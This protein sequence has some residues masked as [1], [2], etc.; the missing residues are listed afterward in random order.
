MSYITGKFF[1][2][3]GGASG[4]GLATCRMLAQRKAKAICIADYKDSQFGLVKTEL[5]GINAGA[6][7]IDLLKVDVSSSS[8]VAAWAEGVFS[9]YETLDGCVNAAGV[10][11]AVGARKDVVNILGESDQTWRRT[12]G[13][14]LDGVF[15]CNREQVRVML[16]CPKTRLPRSIVNIGSMASKMHTPDAFAYGASKAACAHLS[17]CIA[18][19]VLQHGIRVNTILPGLFSLLQLAEPKIYYILI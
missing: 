13:A 14:N 3:T 8:E 4:M 16:K 7:L 6:T 15:Y 5:E 10:A 11:Q 9:K 17:T 12:M 19:D 2:V 1:A 18:K